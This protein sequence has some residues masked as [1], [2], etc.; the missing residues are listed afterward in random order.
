MADTNKASMVERDTVFVFDLETQEQVFRALAQ[1]LVRRDLVTEA[2]LPRITAREAAYPTGMDMSL[3]HPDMPSFAI[4]HT[5]P[6]Y[7]NVTR[8]VPVA[9]R[10]SVPWHVIT[11]PDKVID[12]S[13][14]FAILN[15]GGSSQARLLSRIMDLVNRLGAEGAKRLFSIYDPDELFDELNGNL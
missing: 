14:L 7:V 10:R 1:E 13:F 9:L 12:V 15:S 4:P 3:V 8:I 2:F 11:D 6:A 5:D